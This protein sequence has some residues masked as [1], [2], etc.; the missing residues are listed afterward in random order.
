MLVTVSLRPDGAR[1]DVSGRT[2]KISTI[3]NA[4][5]REIAHQYG[6]VAIEV[7]E[8]MLLLGLAPLEEMSPNIPMTVSYHRADNSLY[9]PEVLIPVPGYVQIS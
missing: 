6:N 3:E 5:V 4:S 2:E 9:Y 8:Q 7:R 1:L